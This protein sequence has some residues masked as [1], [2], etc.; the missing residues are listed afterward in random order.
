MA[1]LLAESVCHPIAAIRLIQIRSL[2]MDFNFR[3]EDINEARSSQIDE[4]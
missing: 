1:M 2:C 3:D 4:A